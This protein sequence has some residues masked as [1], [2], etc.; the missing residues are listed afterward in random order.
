MPYPQPHY[1]LSDLA[2]LDDRIE[3]NID[4]LRIAGE[5]GWEIC[6]EAMA[7]EEPGEIFTAGVLA[8]ESKIPDRMDALLA[9]VEKEREL[10]RALVSA[11]GW[12]DFDRIAE[13]ARKLLDAEL[14]FLRLIGLSTYAVHRQDP[15]PMLAK[16]IS[17]EDPAVRARALKAVGELGRSDLLALTLDHL[18][19][20]DDKS[21]FYAAWSAAI[22][23]VTSA[24]AAL[25]TIA[26]TE[27][28]Y[29][30]RA[31]TLAVRK[32]TPGDATPWLEKLLNASCED[33]AGYSW[34]WCLRRS[35]SHSVA[36]GADAGA[37]IGPTGRRGFLNDHGGGPG[38]S[39]IL[40][41]KCRKGSKPAPQK[42]P[43]MKMWPWTRTKT[44]PGPKSS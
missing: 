29:S 42:I 41:A 35:G 27:S 26:E 7:L 34:F 2:H 10:Q 4:G 16:L 36:D 19:D 33:E 18:T 12:I 15:G 44:C 9:A 3:A 39:R 6:R 37:G 31:C 17:D 30:E 40:K 5:E 22:L 25:Q 8:F 11:L 43:K 28:P 13:P 32:M 20:G 24:V 23:G 38:L 1:D 21:R 14:P